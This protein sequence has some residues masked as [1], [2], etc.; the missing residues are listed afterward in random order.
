MVIKRHDAL[1]YSATIFAH[2]ERLCLTTIPTWHIYSYVGGHLGPQKFLTLKISLIKSKM[3]DLTA[4]RRE[5][6][7]APPSVLNRLS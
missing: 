5:A 1:S 2:F 4:P 6:S 3:I 7:I